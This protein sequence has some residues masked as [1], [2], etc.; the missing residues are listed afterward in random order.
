MKPLFGVLGIFGTIFSLTFVATGIADSRK[1]RGKDH[2]H[3]IAERPDGKF[4]VTCIDGSLE[5]RTQEEIDLGRVCLSIRTFRGKWEL[6]EKSVEWCESLE[7]EITRNAGTIL[8]LYGGFGCGMSMST[9]QQCSGMVCA[10][11]LDG[12]FYSMDF[13]QEKSMRLTRLA[14]GAT[15]VYD[16]FA[17]GG[18][19]NVRLQTVGQV[20]NI[21][22]A[23]NDGGTTWAAV[24]DDNF[25]AVA[26][27]VACREM[28]F[29]NYYD[30]RVGVSA[31]SGNIFG[32][33]EVKCGGDENSIFECEHS[34]WGNEDCGDSEHVQIVCE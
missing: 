20:L 9:T 15:A 33:D 11:K 18:S 3:Q 31:P 17:G 34:P 26:A 19:S 1:V 25:T 22:Q 21:L 28:G 27:T 13:S 30:F 23:S 4:D 8:K 32:L 7:L 29:S 10:M 12:K 14:D 6:S 2:A 5:V 24:C 16:G